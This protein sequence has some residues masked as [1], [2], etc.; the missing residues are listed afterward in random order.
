MAGGGSGGHI[1]PILSLAQES[2]RLRPGCRI[3]YIGQTG[4]KIA[5]LADN[6]SAIDD[7]KTIRA[8]KFRRYHG[9]SKLH[10]VLDIQTNL[11]NLADL[12]NLLIGLVQAWLLLAR[13]RPNV[14]F[15]KGGF[16][17]V[18]VAFAARFWRIPYI[19]HDSDSIPGLANR[20]I[21]GHAAWHATGMPT[22]F[23][24]YPVSNTSYTGVPVAESFKPVDTAQQKA[25]K[26]AIALSENEELLLV[27][28]GGLG[29]DRLNQQFLAIAD[30]LI[31]NR[32][33]L[34]IVHIAGRGLYRQLQSQYADVLGEKYTLNV[35]VIDFVND[36]YVYSGAADVII[37][38][39]GATALAE[40]A[41]QQKAC[42]VVPNPLLASGHQLKNAESLDNLGAAIVVDENSN[43]E[44]LDAING[45]LDNKSKRET[46]G[47]ALGK[48]ANP[49][50][51]IELAKLI[52]RFAGVDK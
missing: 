38:R 6:H 16:V 37:S 9:R 20:L 7:V 52:L 32:P 45:L 28:G 13:Y 12:F 18:P 35:A 4:D 26:R 19:T 17:G 34:R 27:I 48:T 15:V 5:A 23:Y 41:M 43:I 47:K 25:F 2:K 36:V 44:L 51:T 40:F 11:L 10:S 3:I 46:L 33:S 39:A 14:L 31:K 42:I 50:A 24:N 22:K 30:Q 21:G 1:T 8:G 49:M 29:A